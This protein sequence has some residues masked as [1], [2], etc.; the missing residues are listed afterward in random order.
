MKDDHM[1]TEQGKLFW[2]GNS[3]LYI[4]K[5]TGY[6]KTTVYQVMAKFDAKVKLNEVTQPSK[7]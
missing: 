5:S 6:V 4:I 3:S 7:G 2:T 1:Q